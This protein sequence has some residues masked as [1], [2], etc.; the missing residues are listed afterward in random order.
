M[1][2]ILTSTSESADQL[3]EALTSAGHAVQVQTEGDAPEKSVGTS[4]KQAEKPAD[5]VA[6]DTKPAEKPASASEPDGDKKKTEEPEDKSKTPEETETTTKPAADDKAPPKGEEEARSK[7]DRKLLKRIDAVTAQK[8]QLKETLEEQAAQIAELQAKLSGKTLEEPKVEEPTAPVRPRMPVASDAEIGYDEDKLT[9]A[10]AKYE[11]DLDRY[12]ADKTEYIKTQAVKEHKENAQK[13]RFEQ[14]ARAIDDAHAKRVKEAEERYE[15]W[16]EATDALDDSGFVLHPAV[17]NGIKESEAG[18]DIIHHLATHL[19]EAEQLSNM[20][21]DRALKVIGRL[22]A[23]FSDG[24]RKKPRDKD[25]DAEPEKKKTSETEPSQ[26]AE[27]PADTS[28]EKK[29][30]AKEQ[31]P[32]TT[33]NP[34]TGATSLSPGEIAE[35]QGPVVEYMRLRNAEREAAGKRP[36]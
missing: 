33:L 23:K 24:G 32:I 12:E 14:E 8:N 27:K 25:A 36:Y 16:G 10:R 22:E 28:S 15:D 35:K 29:T 5:K 20:R 9:A 34:G 4:E 13:E 17:Y 18:A 31:K 21:P 19:D 3:T 2:V 1:A 7:P 26:K 11:T 30:P 6:E